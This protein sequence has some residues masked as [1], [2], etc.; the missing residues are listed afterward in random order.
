MSLNSSQSQQ[1]MSDRQRRML[2]DM[3]IDVWT[4]RSASPI[5]SD[6]K[7]SAEATQIPSADP[8]QPSLAEI[9]ASLAEVSGRGATRKQSAQAAQ[10]IPVMESSVGTPPAETPEVLQADRIHL[11]FAKKANVLY[12]SDVPIGGPSQSFVQD[13]L[14][15][16][17]WR[18]TNGEFEVGKKPLLSEFQW[19]VVATSG[20][21]ERAVAAFLDKHGL[22]SAEGLGLFSPGAM[23]V[24]KPW[25]PSATSRFIEVPDIAELA[26][27]A[28]AKEK[29]WGE[30][31][32]L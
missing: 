26:S 9:K 7:V 1:Q 21:P 19:P 32:R 5:F 2:A 6:A 29:L 17:N 13:L 28:L 20:T 8:N 25:L 30:V 11:Y 18:V 31:G 14:M 12:I 15:F 3:G 22:T 23:T 16:L 4:S 27:N 24:L 10:I